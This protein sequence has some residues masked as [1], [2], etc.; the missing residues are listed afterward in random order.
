M[1]RRRRHEQGVAR[2]GAPDPVLRAPELARLF[3]GTAPGSQDDLVHLA[4]QTQRK[5]E[6]VADA[7]DAML[8][9]GNVV[10]HLG[11]IVEFNRGRFIV[12]V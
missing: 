10:G 12:L 8:D 6:A 2:T 5:W 7:R 3:R 11:D 1:V 9:R 4:D